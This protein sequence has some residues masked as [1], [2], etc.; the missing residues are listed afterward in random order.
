VLRD[1]SGIHNSKGERPS[2]VR[3]ESCRL[4]DS[5]VPCMCG[6]EREDRSRHLPC[7]SSKRCNYESRAS[8]W[9][10]LRLWH[11][12]NPSCCYGLGSELSISITVNASIRHIKADER[13]YETLL[14]GG[15]NDV[16]CQSQ[17]FARLGVALGRADRVW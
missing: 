17:T 9:P 2:A 15:G 1:K 11:P 12:S 8:W 14:S 7:S 16:T 4:F 5:L 3:S 6:D 13:D 10:L